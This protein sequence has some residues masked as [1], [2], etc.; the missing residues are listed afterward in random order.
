MVQWVMSDAVLS[1]FPS[2]EERYR[3]L[4]ALKEASDGKMFLEREYAQVV[5]WI[6]EML[7]ADGKADEATKLIQEI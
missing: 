3:M 1:K 4:E 2:R 5:R 7:E 6:A